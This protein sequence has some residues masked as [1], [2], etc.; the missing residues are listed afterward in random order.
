MSKNVVEP[1]GRDATNFAALDSP[2][3][4]VRF[5]RV[6]KQMRH[7]V[8]IEAFG[9][10]RRRRRRVR[11]SRGAAATA[12]GGMSSGAGYRR[13]RRHLLRSRIGLFL[14]DGGGALSNIVDFD[15]F[16]RRFVLAVRHVTTRG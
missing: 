7:N 13:R 2:L 6:A 10:I 16:I 9:T 1:V 3:V 12:V 11:R 14:I 15:F 5:L 4:D 8:R